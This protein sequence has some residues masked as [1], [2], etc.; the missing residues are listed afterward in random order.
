VKIIIW[1]G[2]AWETWGEDSL[3]TGIGGSE[4]AATYLSRELALRGHEVEV[5]GQVRPSEDRHGPGTVRFVDHREFAEYGGPGPC[6]GQVVREGRATECDVFVSSRYLSALGA[7][8]PDARLKV[9]WMHDVH[10]GPDTYRRLGGYDSVLCLS[11]WALELAQ[12][13]YPHVPADRFVQTRNGI[14]LDLYQLDPV[15]EGWRV[16]YSSSPDRGLDRLLDFWP[17]VKKLRPDAELHVYYGF[18]T[19][20]KMAVHACDDVAAAQIQIYKTRLAAMA[21]QGVVSHGRVGQPELAAAWLGTS[22]WLYPTNFSETSCITAMEAQAA[23]AY[24]VCSRQ[25]ALTETARYALLVDP[26]NTREGY[27]ETFLQCVENV[28]RAPGPVHLGSRT[29][30]LRELGWAGVAAQWEDLFRS[31]LGS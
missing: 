18:D 20:E 16:V 30:A 23:G 1:T 25:A 15:K 27:R 11:R 2:P 8:R 13:F 4:A 26:P 19:W 3:L 29:W 9:L 5:V 12:R 7:V 17:T 10:A 14:P 28:S 6:D 31:R 24:C 22:A 21:G